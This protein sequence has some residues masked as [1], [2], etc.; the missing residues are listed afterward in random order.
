[1]LY[2]FFFFKQKTAYELRISDWSSDVC[3][4]DLQRTHHD[5]AD[6][7]LTS[8]DDRRRQVV[9][10]SII[11]AYWAARSRAINASA[12]FSISSRVLP[13]TRYLPPTTSEGVERI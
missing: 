2:F 1:M 12:L 5:R 11:P 7:R 8:R 10:A 4:S 9:P 6:R 13:L 3:S